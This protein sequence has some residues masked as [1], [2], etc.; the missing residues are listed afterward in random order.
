[1]AQFLNVMTKRSHAMMAEGRLDRSELAKYCKDAHNTMA[2][3]LAKCLV[4]AEVADRWTELAR[5]D[6]DPNLKLVDEKVFKTELDKAM[7][8][9]TDE[10]R[11]LCGVVVDSVPTLQKPARPSIA[12]MWA[13]L[14]DAKPKRTRKAPVPENQ[15][16][17]F[18]FG[19][20]A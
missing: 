2:T 1:M 19:L 11:R 18:D 17:L 13:M 6:I 4:A 7:K 14:K 20:G 12:D 10:T 9:L 8:E 15:I 5:K 16:S 3:D